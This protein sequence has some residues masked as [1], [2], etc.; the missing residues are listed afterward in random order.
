MDQLVLLVQKRHLRLYGVEKGW[1]LHGL[2]L[3]RPSGRVSF[4]DA[5]L[6]A[7]AQSA[8]AAVIYSFDARFPRSGIEV[9]QEPQ[10]S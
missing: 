7:T 5:I 2:L 4:A 1:M 8:G 6:W 3:C 10:S 9:R